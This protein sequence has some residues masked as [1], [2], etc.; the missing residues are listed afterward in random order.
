MRDYD[1][2]PFPN[3]PD[4]HC[5]ST[6]LS[7]AYYLLVQRVGPTVAGR[8]LNNVSVTFSPRPTFQEVARAFVARAAHLFPAD[9][10]D[11]GTDSDTAQLAQASFGLVGLNV[12]LPRDHR[13]P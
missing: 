1:D 13:T 9:G 11:P 6:I 12:S 10:P 7:H 2:T 4:P 3:E 5:N 8:L